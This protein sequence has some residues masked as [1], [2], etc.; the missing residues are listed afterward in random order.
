MFFFLNLDAVS[1][2]G[3]SDREG[4]TFFRLQVHVYVRISLVT[5]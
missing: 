5:V 3:D 2:W 4:G 1:G